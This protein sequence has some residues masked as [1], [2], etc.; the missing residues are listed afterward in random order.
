MNAGP[1]G[2]IFVHGHWAF[3]ISMEMESERTEEQ[4]RS[5]DTAEDETWCTAKQNNSEISEE[6][7]IHLDPVHCCNTHFE[8]IGVNL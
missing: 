5:K 1:D 2:F 8:P 6:L 7:N 4:R 3:F